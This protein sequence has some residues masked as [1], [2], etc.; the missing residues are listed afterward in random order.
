MP[1][2]I[3]NGY[4]MRAWYDIRDADFNARADLAGVRASQAQVEAL[5]ARER[6]RGIAGVAHR[7]RAASRRAAR[8]RSTPACAIRERLAGIVALSTYLIDAGRARRGGGAGES[9]RADLHGARH[10]GSGRALPLG[11][12]VAQALVAGGWPSSGTRTRWRTPRCPRRSPRPGSFWR[13]FSRR[14]GYLRRGGCRASHA[15]RVDA[16]N[17]NTPATASRRRR[18]RCSRR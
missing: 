5:I 7:A 4:V 16:R 2:T 3:N 17:R 11:G 12:R 8:S 10:A 14:S 15:N 1:V 9:R 13:E 6:A 18:W